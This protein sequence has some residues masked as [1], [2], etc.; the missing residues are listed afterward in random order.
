[1]LDGLDVADRQK[2]QQNF[3]LVEEYLNNKQIQACNNFER[4]FKLELKSRGCY[5]RKKEYGRMYEKYYL[6]AFEEFK[7][8]SDA[9]QEIFPDL[10]NVIGKSKPRYFE[11]LKSCMESQKDFLY[12]IWEIEKDAARDK[13]DA[14]KSLKNILRSLEKLQQSCEKPKPRKLIRMNLKLVS[15]FDNN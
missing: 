13:R 6:K 5:L 3:F 9:F 4:F 10:G 7:Q 2:D 15:D 11:K 8:D 12:Q 14:E 1:M